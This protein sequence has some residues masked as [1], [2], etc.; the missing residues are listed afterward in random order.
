MPRVPEAYIESR[1]RDIILAARRAFLEQGMHEATMAEIAREAGI[2]PGA[3]YR[4]FP[5]KEELAHACCSENADAVHHIWEGYRPGDDPMDGMAAASIRTFALLDEPDACD[6]TVIH[7][8]F[9]LS[10]LRAGESVPLAHIRDEREKIVERMAETF[11]LAQEKGQL[12]PNLNPRP[13]AEALFAFYWGVRI[14]K[15]TAPGS[16]AT[17]QFAEVMKLLAPR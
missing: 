1:R 5:S 17:A 10:S 13:L 16:S 6:D 8:E 7:L 9:L 14:D 15:L 12:A 2:T 4:Y 3:I 11:R